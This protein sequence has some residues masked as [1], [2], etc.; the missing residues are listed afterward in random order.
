M[1]TFSNLYKKLNKEQKIAVDTIDGPIM[2]IAGPGT[3]KTLTLTMRI[4]NI[5]RK[6]DTDPRSI[7]ALTFTDSATKEMRN[8]LIEIMGA[9]SYYVNIST[10]HSFCTEIIK[11][12]PDEFLITSDTAPLS[13][14]EKI[15]L[16][17]G[18]F[19]TLDLN[20]LKPIN[21][22]YYYIHE[23]ISKIQILK[24]EN[25][26]PDKL[27]DLIK[28]DQKT[29][30]NTEDVI[31]PR[32]GKPYVKYSQR[33]K[34]ID[35]QKEL[36]KIYREYAKRIKEMKRFD[37]EDMIN[38][39][40]DKLNSDQNFKLTLQERYLY[41]LVDEYQDT[42]NAQNEILRL[43]TDH[44]EEP[45]IFVVGDDEQSIFRFQGA[46]LENILY[47]KKLFK[48]AKTITLTSNYRSSQH[49]LDAAKSL[50]E[51]NKLRLREKDKGLISKLKH[52]NI[53]V[54]TAQFPDSYI[55]NYYLAKTI[56]SLIKKR[57]DPDEIAILVKENADTRD[58]KDILSQVGIRYETASGQ[59]I[60]ENGDINRLL[61]L[62]EVIRDIREKPSDDI[63]L[64]TLLYYDFLNFNKLDVLKLSRYASEKRQNLIEVI[65]DRDV[66]NE[67]NI[68]EPKK[69]LELLDQLNRW[70]DLDSNA[71]F[72]TFLQVVLQESG[73]IDWILSDK[74]N[75][76]RINVLNTLFNKVKESNYADHTLSLESFLKN[77]QIMR[78][79]NI[80]IEEKF[81]GED[82]QAVKLLTAYKA[83]GLEFEYVFVPKCVDRK[84][85]NKVVRDLI[86]LPDGIIKNIDLE[87]KEQNEDDRRVFYVALTRA[88]KELFITYAQEYTENGTKRQKV[89]S[90]F[91]EEIDR[92]LKERIDISDFEKGIHEQH[93]NQLKLPISEEHILKEEDFLNRVLANF[94]LSITKLNAYLKCPYKFKLNNI[95]KTP[96]VKPTPQAFGTAVHKAL[97]EFFKEFKRLKKLP[98]KN[99]LLDVF[100]KALEKELLSVVD[101]KRLKK[102]GRETLEE[103]YKENKKDFKE[104]ISTEYYFGNRKIVL[105]G[106]PLSGKVDK[107]EW[108]DKDKKQVRVTDYKTGSPKTR[109]EIEG[110]TKYSDGDLIRQLHFYK[111]LSQLDYNFNYEVVE[112]EFDFVQSSSSRKAK[113]EKHTYNQEDIEDLKTLITN[114]MKDIRN[115]KFKKTKEYRHCQNCQY[116]DHCWPD[117]IP[118]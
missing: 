52:K 67:T 27:H 82:R 64:F 68:K 37:F 39:V 26:S 91:I 77:I 25:I 117:G 90:M 51:K 113:K 33:Q 53:P 48:K 65:L 61:K 31:N 29:L 10:F 111:L 41:I 56:Q 16:F 43:L 22:Q 71:P 60:L 75:I 3:G 94:K 14:L 88:K 107:I 19:D 72:S 92:N 50:I 36:L 118:R 84:W 45:N 70:K 103:Y 5:L 59:N 96:R 58:I 7:L 6:T 15:Q 83:K 55:E 4:A 32:T 57:V 69:F 78:E 100:E 49:I 44:W 54:S 30:D 89:P 85:G 108:V 9:T 79:N 46:S 106:I 116:N 104:P 35:K 105:R 110:K 95:L 38:L 18:I 66:F 80:K 81:L 8:R 97:E 34:N 1:S 115:L 63:D 93:E 102:K 47:F 86:K 109:G 13:E 17:R 40:V 73:F 12:F 76:S 28:D 20:I 62:F 11:E 42:N 24:R 87:K 98:T 21:N 23:A 101:F 74:H 99:K 2:I 112:G 114:S